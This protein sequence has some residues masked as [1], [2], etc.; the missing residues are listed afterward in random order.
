[1]SD[2][3]LPNIVSFLR[4]F[5]REENFEAGR[6]RHGSKFRTVEN[7]C[8]G[9]VDGDEGRGTLGGGKRTR[10]KHKK[11]DGR[12]IRGSAEGKKRKEKQDI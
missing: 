2:I 4:D 11:T 10:Q 5:A 8:G 6:R 12:Y 1:V 9:F 3:F 7:S